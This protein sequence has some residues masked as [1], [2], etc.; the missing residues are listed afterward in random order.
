MRHHSTTLVLLLALASRLSAQQPAEHESHDM[1]DMHDAPGS[2]HMLHMEMTPGRAATRSDSVRAADVAR[3]LKVALA[4][5]RDPKAAEADGFRLFAPN[6]RN[7]RI[8]HYTNYRYA[9][10]EAFR[11][12]PAKPTS[13]LYRKAPDGSMELVGAMYSAPKRASVAKLDQRVPLSIAHWHRHVNLCSPKKG[14]EERY[15]ERKDGAPLFGPESPIATKQACD[16]VNGEFRPNL[17][18]WMVHANVML[19]DDPKVVWGDDH[20]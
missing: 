20:K 19:S 17:F 18:G 7:Q 2:A 13:I 5:Y 1:M 10:E 8:Y 11:F 16:A 3:T 14:E 12:N 6:M 9:L 4:K 15:T